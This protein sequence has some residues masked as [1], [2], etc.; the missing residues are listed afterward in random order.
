[1]QRIENEEGG[2]IAKYWT[3]KKVKSTSS[4]LPQHLT[5]TGKLKDTFTEM[6][7]RRMHMHLME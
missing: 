3:S 4:S 1:M 5:D 2:K 6:K 7:T